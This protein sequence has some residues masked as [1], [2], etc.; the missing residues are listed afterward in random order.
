MRDGRIDHP[1]TAATRNSRASNRLEPYPDG[2]LHELLYEA[3]E[4]QP[5]NGLHQRGAHITYP[6]V[7]EAAE[8][9]ASVPWPSA[10]SDPVDRVATILP[11]SVQFVVATHG[12]TLA[13]GVHVP[14]DFLDA[15]EDLVYRLEQADPTVLIGHDEHLDLLLEL[16]DRIGIEHLIVTSMDDYSEAPPD[17]EP[18]EGAEWW[19]AVLEEASG[20]VPDV[21]VDGDDLHTLLFTGGTTG[22][23]KGCELTHSNVY[24]NVHQL[25]GGGG[26]AQSIA[27]MVSN[28]LLALPMYH[29]YGY[30][31]GAVLVGRGMDIVLVDDPR[32]T[33]R[34]VEL[35]EDHALSVVMGVPAQFI[36]LVEEDIDRPLIGISGSA[37]LAGDTQDRFAEDHLAISQGYGL[38]EMLAT[39]VN[40]GAIRE[41]LGMGD[42]ADPGFDRPSIGVPLPDTD[43]KLVDIDSGEEIPLERAAEEGLEG[44]MYL[45]GPQR[46]PGLSGRLAQSLR[47]RW[48]RRDG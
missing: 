29:T 15:T 14:N 40:M 37:P 39:H 27:D 9:L 32:D 36:D 33:D 10:A 13:G 31:I 16:R 17:H 4:T 6:E 2:P 38:S 5:D 21:D 46:M 7:V 44:E 26:E 1:G 41:Q 30:L 28:V 47:H 22:R 45:N 18:L 25:T 3:A 11:T 48:V 19:P 43:A 34:M 23:P 42:T 24:A 8:R 12:I 20:A 35:I